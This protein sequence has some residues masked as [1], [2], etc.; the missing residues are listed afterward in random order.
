MGPASCRLR[1]KIHIQ[2]HLSEPQVPTK[3]LGAHE[4]FS[5]HDAKAVLLC[6]LRDPRSTVT[7]PPWRHSK[8]NEYRHGFST[9]LMH[10]KRPSALQWMGLLCT[11]GGSYR[12]LH[13]FFYFLFFC[14]FNQFFLQIFLS[15]S[16]IPLSIIIFS[17]FF[18]LHLFSHSYSLNVFVFNFLCCHSVN[19]TS[20]FILLFSYTIIPLSDLILSFS[21]LSSFIYSSIF[22]L[23]FFY[24][25]FRHSV[26]HF[27]FSIIPSFHLHFYLP[28]F[29]HPYFNSFF[30]AYFYSLIL[31]TH[32]STTL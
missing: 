3:V 26:I 27:S 32:P 9:S 5:H 29:L 1:L 2:H 7:Y 23:S 8:Y 30:L 10:A 22:I 19:F 15:R 16:F 18:N 6:W 28:L 13:P 25:W 4:V 21:Y 12:S 20:A 17:F 31:F 24:N 14:N 11:L